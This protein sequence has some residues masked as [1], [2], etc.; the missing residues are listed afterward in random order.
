MENTNSEEQ[1]GNT[2]TITAEFI[3]QTFS[4]FTR[5]LKELTEWKQQV[6][7]II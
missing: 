1:G 7:N 4:Q 3:E 6:I 5:T 2:P